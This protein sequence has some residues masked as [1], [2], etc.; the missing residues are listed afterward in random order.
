MRS[1][2]LFIG[3]VVFSLCFPNAAAAQDRNPPY[4]MDKGVWVL[5]EKKPDFAPTKDDELYFNNHVSAS[6]N[7]V[8]GG[9]SWK[10]DPVKPKCSGTVWGT[11]AWEELPAVIPPGVGQNTM[12]RAE[13]GGSQSCAY[14]HVSA[15]TELA[16]N[17]RNL[18]EIY[19][20]ISYPT[21]DPKP[22]PVSVKVP[23]QAPW[24]KIGDTLTV[25]VIAQVPG[26]VS[27]HF[28]YNYI[29]AYEAPGSQAEHTAPPPQAKK[30]DLKAPKP[31]PGNIP[32]ACGPCGGSDSGVRFS[33]VSGE[34][35]LRPDCKE[36]AWKTA[37]I[38]TVPCVDDHVRTGEDSSAILTF[39]D[40]TWFVMKA[41]TEIILDVAPR[42]D[43]KIKLVSGNIWE[44]VK[45]M[46]REGQMEVEMSQAVTSIK[47]T[48]IVCEETGSSSTLKVLEGT[49]GFTSKTTGKG[50]LVSAGKM[51][52]ATP[53]G[54]S[55]PRA[56]DVAAEKANWR[57]P[58]R[59]DPRDAKSWYAE[60]Y[61]LARQNKH[62]AAVRAYDEAL[63]LDPKTRTPG[64]PRGRISG[65]RAII[66]EALMAYNEVIR[67]D[68]RY[69]EAW[70]AKG[71]VLSRQDKYD[72][73]GNAFDEVIR[74]DPR[75]ADA[76]QAKGV[77]LRKLGRAKEADAAFA[78]A[79]EL[80]FTS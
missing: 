20:H 11:C 42:Q 59:K 72:A 36:R 31:V 16:I 38:A 8:N 26:A 15:R 19:A 29:Y 45:K 12:L 54:L 17:D 75:R 44:K 71:Y 69:I 25:T 24:G 18:N 6:G 51:A 39:A 74:I 48:T 80:G 37:E 50:I 35:D 23:W 27:N 55:L 62:A 70:Y 79:K 34:V 4:G 49:A 52:T 3:A 41:E 40:M 9:W 68:P 14:R 5:K 22:A 33:D 64:T 73:A 78:R 32:E 10:D 56:F 60:G 61:A 58:A 67:L 2:A 66:A 47:G 13:V 65:S 43:A 76:W 21:C 63:R 77:V 53:S 28:Y 7:T 1:K 46:V 30:P 57:T